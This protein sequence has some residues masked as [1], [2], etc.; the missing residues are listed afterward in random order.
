[1]GSRKGGMVS[2]VRMTYTLQGGLPDQE[3]LPRSYNVG[4]STDIQEST[5]TLCSMCGHWVVS[6]TKS[7][8]SDTIP[9]KLICQILDSIQ[10]LHFYRSTDSTGAFTVVMT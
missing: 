6:L 5:K 10:L 2:R 8:Q 7:A 3:Y 1:M 4:I 9:T